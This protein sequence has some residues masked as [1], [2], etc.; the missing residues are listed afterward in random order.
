MWRRSST[1]KIVIVEL[2]AGGLGNDLDNDL[3]LTILQARGSGLEGSG[4]GFLQTVPFAGPAVAA[5]V[6]GR[7]TP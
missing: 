7:P 3:D 1:K 4:V 5:R 2:D 6:S